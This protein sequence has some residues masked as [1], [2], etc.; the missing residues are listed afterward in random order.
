MYAI[1]FWPEVTLLNSYYLVIQFGSLYKPG[2]PAVYW[3]QKDSSTTST[4]KSKEKKMLSNGDCRAGYLHH[5][6]Q[7]YII[8]I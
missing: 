5:T 2:A 1:I 3:K 6:G 7:Y 8:W 4:I